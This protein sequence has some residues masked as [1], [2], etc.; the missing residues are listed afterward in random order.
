MQVPD[1]HF[2]A[3]APVSEQ[4]EPHDPLRSARSAK[5]RGPTLLSRSPVRRVGRDVLTLPGEPVEVEEV[6]T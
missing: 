1:W 6:A 5:V 2:V 4:T 3:D